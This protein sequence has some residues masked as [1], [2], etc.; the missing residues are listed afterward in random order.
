M[1]LAAAPRTGVVPDP[2]DARDHQ[3]VARNLVRAVLVRAVVV[4]NRH[5][6]RN[7]ASH[8]PAVGVGV[9]GLTIAVRCSM[10]ISATVAHSVRVI[11]VG[12]ARVLVGAIAVIKDATKK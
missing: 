4:R 12:T 6:A 8:S 2:P 7:H 10:L 11:H 3:V 5:H 1:D 9:G